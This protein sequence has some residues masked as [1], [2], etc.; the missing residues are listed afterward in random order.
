MKANR[1]NILSEAVANQI[2]AGEVVQRPAN[3]VKELVENSIDAGATLVD[4][5][6]GGSGKSTI[7]VTDN[8][9]GMNSTDALM[10]FERHATSKISCF[11]DLYALA[12]NGF[13]GEALP[14]ISSVASVTLKTSDEDE[15]IG[16]CVTFKEGRFDSQEPCAWKKGTQV[17][18]D[19]I[20]SN[21][22][23]R[24][25]FMKS[26]GIE[27]KHIIET[28]LRIALVYPEVAFTL[29]NE[30]GVL[31]DL[32][33]SSY[34]QRIAKV[35]G[36]NQMGMNQEQ[37]LVPVHF[38]SSLCNIEGFVG[39]PESAKAKAADQQMFFVNGRFMRHG[40]F[41]KAVLTAMDRL[42][43]AG[44]QV[45]YFLYFDVNPEDIDVNVHPTK[46]D[47]K[48]ENEQAIFDM[49]V[50]AVRQ[51]VGGFVQVNELY[52]SS[53][54][55]M[56]KATANN[57]VSLT[58][59]PTNNATSAPKVAS[60]PECSMPVAS[61]TWEN[62]QASVAEPQEEC[63]FA[64]PEVSLEVNGDAYI[65]F[66]AKYIIVNTNK[67]LMLV[68]QEY[69]HERILFD[70]YRAKYVNATEVEQLEM[71]DEY[72]VE[73]DDDVEARVF[74]LAMARARREGVAEGQPLTSEEMKSIVCR[75]LECEN[76]CYTPTGKRIFH[77]ITG[78]NI[79]E[80]I[81]LAA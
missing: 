1:I 67:G 24:R 32:E 23:V 30:G 74:N 61:M 69:A 17:Q 21:I 55:A 2:A 16:T 78:E 81:R 13:R 27:R 28:F 43:P 47:I 8:G 12:T 50:G 7:I 25:R 22:P 6:V 11:E 35:F 62:I 56:P 9:C 29:S 63:L 75:L 58:K 59:L 34:R 37:W 66:N 38:K 52:P 26:D 49:L 48:F 36:K 3:I 45:P 72:E 44:T 54:C 4:V 65:Q 41:H 57:A 33:P 40:Y 64:V 79:N 68:N 70:E 60:I 77:M 18:V 19:N 71:F 14:S 51:A 76:K 5:Y 15:G 53:P 31:Y 46:T 20:F 80:L 73:N 42:L 10:A 39:R